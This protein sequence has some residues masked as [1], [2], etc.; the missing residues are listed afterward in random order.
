MS[1][2]CKFLPC[3]DVG[4]SKF[5]FFFIHMTF[6]DLP[7]IS[8]RFGDHMPIWSAP[9]TCKRQ[10]FGAKYDPQNQPNLPSEALLH[11]KKNG[12]LAL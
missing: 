5:P 4:G 12:V 9:S 10:L 1:K 2:F 3:P 8:D 6:Q 11:P 7:V